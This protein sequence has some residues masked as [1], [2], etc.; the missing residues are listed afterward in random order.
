MDRPADLR[1][2]ITDNT[3]ISSHTGWKPKRNV[4]KV[5]EDIH[6]WIKANEQQLE[7]ILK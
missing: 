5:F 4:K 1:V 2:Y 6:E 3:A 7:P